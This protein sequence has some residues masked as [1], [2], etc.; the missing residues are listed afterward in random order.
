MKRRKPKRRKIPASSATVK[1]G[2]GDVEDGP[3]RC[4]VN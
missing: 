4:Q 1:E 3:G 2:E